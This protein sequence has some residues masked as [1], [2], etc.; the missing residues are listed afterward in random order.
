[1]GFVAFVVEYLSTTRNSLRSSSR[2]RSA[3]GR[4]A[5]PCGVME[6]GVYWSGNVFSGL[7]WASRW[8]QAQVEMVLLVLVG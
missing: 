2:V 4:P 5:I 8:E 6:E 3:A 1:M 7:N